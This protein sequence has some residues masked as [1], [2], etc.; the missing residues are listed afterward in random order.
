M[1][2]VKAEGKIFV[3][4]NNTNGGKV[5]VNVSDDFSRYYN[6]FIT[7]KHWISLGT[8]MFKP[9]ITV[10]NSK[11]HDNIDWKKA[12]KLKNKLIEFEYDVD[13]IQGGYHKGFIMFYIKVYSKE[14]DDIKSDLGIIE[15]PNY[16]GLHITIANSKGTNMQPWWPKMIEILNK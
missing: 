3:E 15:G 13:M 1:H 2:L 14:L 16:K 10:A 7:R 8:P 6:W 11:F 9:H 5:V 12:F 4:R